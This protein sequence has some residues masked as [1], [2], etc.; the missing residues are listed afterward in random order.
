MFRR[1]AIA[2]IALVPLLLRRAGGR[3]GSACEAG[4][5]PPTSSSSPSTR[6]APITSRGIAGWPHAATPVLDGRHGRGTRFRRDSAAPITLPSHA[7][8][9]T[10]L[11]PPR[12]G[13]RDSGTF[14]L[15]AGSKTLAEP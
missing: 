12:H 14:T 1:L 8:I 4:P 6:R 13:V 2:G 7:T 10:G 5:D 15:A 9:L 3:G 11:F